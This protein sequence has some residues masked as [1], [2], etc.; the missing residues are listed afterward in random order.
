MRTLYLRPVV[1]FFFVFLGALT[2]YGQVKIGTQPETINPSSLLELEST[3]QVLVI[4]RVNTAQMNAIMPLEGA[5]VYN[6]DAQC[7]HYYNGVEW[8]NICEAFGDALSFTSNNI[9]DPSNQ[10]PTIKIVQTDNNY[11]FE[12]GLISGYNLQDGIVDTEHI[13]TGAITQTKIKDDAINSAKIANGS[14]QTVDI[15][16]GLPNTVLQTNNM[17]N[18]VLWAPLDASV[19]TGRDLTPGDASITITD[20]LGATLLDTDVRV[21][22]LGI[23]TA[24]LADDAVTTAKILDAN[25]TDAKLDKANI[26]LT[27]FSTPTADLSM[28][29]FKLIDVVDPTDAQDAA[30]KNYVDTAVSNSNILADSNIFIGDVAGLAQPLPISGHATLSNTGVLTIADDA[31]V[32]SK[33]LDA[34]VTDAKLDK[35]NIPLSGFG[36]A[37]ADIDIGSYRIRNVLDPLLPQDVATL[38]YVNTQIGSVN[39]LADGRI[40]VGNS[41]NSATQVDLSGDATLDNTGVLTIEDDVITTDNIGTAGLTDANKILKTDAAGDPSWQDETTELPTLTDAQIIISDG[42][43]A[44]ARTIS[45]DATI[46]NTGALTIEDDAI[47]TSKILNTN[48]TDAKLDKSN[49]S[50]TGFG[51]PTANLSIGNFKLTDVVDP[52]LDQDAATKKYVDD[53]I[54]ANTADG[55]ETEIT[56]AGINGISGNGTSATPYVI[57]ATEAQDL[58]DVLIISAD[59]NGTVITNLGTPL[60]DADASTKKYVDDQIVTGTTGSIFF[61]NNTTGALTENN[62]QLFW[63]N[64]TNKLG[65]GIA[66]PTS[67]LHT[68]GSFATAIFTTVGDL[69]LSEVHHTI[70][71]DGNHDITLPNANTCIGR[72]YILKKPTTLVSL[73]SAYIDNLGASSTTLDDGITQLQSDGTNWQQI[74]N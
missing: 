20:G 73:I 39:T 27:G 32:T 56:V 11:N 7:L 34:N 44:N 13:V 37:T 38:N 70:I 1:V 61:A 40:F 57:T 67:T 6:T 23:T 24:K 48:V 21:T 64:A 12:V 3:N 41:L 62:S 16:P 15:A 74:N 53:Q 35:V 71:I 45:G 22:N 30:T 59:A 51:V 69:T 18:N 4:S 46:D 19:V 42:T 14:I 50:L 28:G 68:D 54:T 29:T 36:I 31:I 66:T 9:Q 10:F 63:D 25:V 52:T 8:I 47:T 5:M 2:S 17:G 58:E 49:I 43:D 72:I 60:D 33:I 26:S 55:S 65:V